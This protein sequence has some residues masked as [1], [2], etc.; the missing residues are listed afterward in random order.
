M[1]PSRFG[2]AVSPL[3]EARAVFLQPGIPIARLPDARQD[4]ARQ[5]Q[6]GPTQQMNQ[7]QRPPK[8]VH[9]RRRKS[10]L[11]EDVAQTVARTQRQQRP[12]VAR[13]VDL[14]RD[15]YRQDKCQ[16]EGS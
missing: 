5:Q 6:Q 14:K 16:D 9:G 3:L 11:R 7:Q 8:A 4:A 13:V 1:R 2:P 10:G 12:N 15:A